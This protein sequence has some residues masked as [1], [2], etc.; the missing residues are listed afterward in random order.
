M[1]GR[2]I[3]I[4]VLKTMVNTYLLFWLS[5]PFIP[6][7]AS[8]HLTTLHSV[9]DSNQTF[10]RFHMERYIYIRGLWGICCLVVVFNPFIGISEW[11]AHLVLV[12]FNFSATVRFLNC[13]S[14]YYCCL[15]AFMVS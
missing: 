1:P 7:K 5:V 2:E 11:H 3:G 8:N 15:S 13:I 6:N 12:F 4:A 10:S 9:G 14:V